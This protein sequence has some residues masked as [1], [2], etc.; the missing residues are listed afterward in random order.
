MIKRIQL[1]KSPVDVLTMQE[2]LEKIDHSIQRGEHLQQVVVNAAKLVHMQTDLALRKSVVESDLINADG[3][4]VVWA[5]RLKGTPLPERVAGIDL[6]ENLVRL[7]ARRGYKIYFFGGKEEVIQKMVANYTRQYGKE[8][9]AGFRNGYF[10]SG[11]ELEIAKSIAQSEADIL[12]VG[13]SSPTKEIFINRYRE[14]LGIPFI[15][16]VGGAFDVISGKTK[17]APVWMQN[18]GLEWFYRFLQEP[19]RMWKRYLVTNTLFLYYFLCELIFRREKFAKEE[20]GG[21]S[22]QKASSFKTR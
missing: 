1:L 18:N 6:M 4:A 22:R 5:A 13:I 10:S 11:E 3:M 2:T 20:E 19:G 14:K 17:R 7:S 15:M 9:I 8:I 16:G 21:N 12:F